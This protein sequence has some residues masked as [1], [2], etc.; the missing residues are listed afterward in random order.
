MTKKKITKKE[1]DPKDPFHPPVGPG[2]PPTPPPS[3]PIVKPEEL[4]EVKNENLD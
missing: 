3:A 1:T 2:H 4:Q